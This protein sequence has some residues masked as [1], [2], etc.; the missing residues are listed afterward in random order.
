MAETM[1][2]AR[3]TPFSPTKT[4][5]TPYPRI[6]VDLYGGALTCILTVF[7][8]GGLIRYNGGC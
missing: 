6:Y 2:L 4:K 3:R 5:V 1:W 8:G 7:S